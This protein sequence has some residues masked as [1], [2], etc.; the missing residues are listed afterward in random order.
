[1]SLSKA[2]LKDLAERLEENLD[3]NAKSADSAEETDGVET[4]K[5]DELFSCLTSSD[6]A[7]LRKAV[8]ENKYVARTEFFNFH[9]GIV[10]VEEKR[11][12]S[13]V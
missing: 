2:E 6:M 8:K 11:D 7:A 3:K 10:M 4:T 12:I 13:S 9:M 1:M 5:L